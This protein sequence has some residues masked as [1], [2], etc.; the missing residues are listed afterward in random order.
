MPWNLEVAIVVWGYFG[1]GLLASRGKIADNSPNSLNRV[2][3]PTLPL[4]EEI[5]YACVKQIV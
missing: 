1:P 4:I 2:C 5:N 3:K